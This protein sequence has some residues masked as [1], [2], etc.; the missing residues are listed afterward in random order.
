MP[1]ADRA[2]SSET[3]K[4]SAGYCTVCNLFIAGAL[5]ARKS[6]NDFPETAS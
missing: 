1:H 4:K 3:P 6:D 2:D 5:A